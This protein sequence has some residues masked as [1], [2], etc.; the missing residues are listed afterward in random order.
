MRIVAD[1]NMNDD[2]IGLLR[3]VGH[4]VWSVSEAAP[5]I[6]DEQVMALAVRTARVLITFDKGFGALIYE[7]HLP[8]PPSVILFRI[9]DVPA[10]GIPHF[11]LGSIAALREW[12]GVFRVI[13]KHGNRSR[14]LPG[15]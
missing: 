5:R 13:Y 1:E 8:P 9:S 4:D 3:S 14:P 7:R 6:A 2:T 12:E 10:E 15:Q 11:V